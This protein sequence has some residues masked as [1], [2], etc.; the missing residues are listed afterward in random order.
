MI[1]LVSS[2]PFNLVA[3][4]MSA[5]SD[6]EAVTLLDRIRLALLLAPLAVDERVQNDLNSILDLAAH[7]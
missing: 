7:K 4:I 6:V 2:Y 1:I 5:N 3:I